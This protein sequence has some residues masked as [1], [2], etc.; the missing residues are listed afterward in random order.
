MKNPTNS[1]QWMNIAIIYTIIMKKVSLKKF[2]FK[3]MS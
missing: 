1:Y 3:L 2:P